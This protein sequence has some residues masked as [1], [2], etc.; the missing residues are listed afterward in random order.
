MMLLYTSDTL[1]GKLREKFFQCFSNQT[2]PTQEHLFDLMLSIMALDG[3][4]SVKFIS[5][6][7]DFS[8][9]SYYFT[10]NRS[11][12]DL[13]DWMVSL[14]HIALSLIPSDC[15]QPL[16]LSIDDTLVEKYGEKFEHYSKLFDHSAHHGNNYLKGHC[17]VSVVLSV[18][19]QNGADCRYLSFPLAYRMWTKAKTKLEMAAELVHEARKAI[20]S[21]YLVALCCDSW[22]PK[23][24]VKELVNELDNFAIICNVRSDTAIY[25]LPPAKSGR[26]RPPKRGKKLSLTDFPLQEVADT[27]FLVGT[28]PVKTK[29]FGDRI[30]YAI[31]TKA[32]NGKSYRL[33][34]CTQKPENI[35]FD[36]SFS[37][38]SD[39]A[40][41]N[42]ERAFLPL[43]IYQLRWNIET[44]YYEQKAFWG[45]GDYMLRSQVGI[46]RL[47]NLQTL[48]YAFV[49][50]LPWL[51]EDFSFLKG[52]SSQQAR[53]TLGKNICQRVFFAT[54]V[55]KLETAKKS[56]ELIE[57]LKTQISG[58]PDAA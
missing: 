14:I 25:D 17:F 21:N 39:G 24:P 57:L 35:P 15:K 18:P 10:L 23:G 28:Q 45:L 54:F 40:Y 43:T 16:V 5:E 2:K 7:T 47:I 31:V 55:A 46:E 37:S 4:Q 11:K 3:F 44:S 8:L 20:G 6:I 58:L 41:A 1:V 22:Y 9:N 48:T 49:R 13:S 12:I 30:V 53:F 32:K 42:A 34:L 33:F 27:D 29:L 38:K 36:T 52:L 56:P 51:S 50:L 19:V 26:G